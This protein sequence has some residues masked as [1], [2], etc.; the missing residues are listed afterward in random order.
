MGM[1]KASAQQTA[2]NLGVRARTP[3]GVAILVGTVPVAPSGVAFGTVVLVISTAEAIA[4]GITPD[5]DTN[6]KCLLYHHV[7]SFFAR[8]GEGQ[9]LYILLGDSDSTTMAAMVDNT[10][11]SLALRTFLEQQEGECPLIGLFQSEA[12]DYVPARTNGLAT[13]VGTA[14]TNLKALLAAQAAKFNYAVCIVEGKDYS[15]THGQLINHRSAGS[16]LNAPRIAIV[17]DQRPSVRAKDTA[18]A[19]YTE[20]GKLLGVL[21]SVQVN[22]NVGRVKSGSIQDDD[23]GLSSGQEILRMDP[24]ALD[25][26]YDK[27]YIFLRKH[28]KRSGFYYVDDLTLAPA[29]D[30][31]SSL[32]AQRT[33]DKASLIAIDTYTNELLDEVVLLPDGRL[34][35]GQVKNFQEKLR[36]VIADQMGNEI[37]SVTVSIDPDQVVASTSELEAELDVVP[38]GTFRSVKTTVAFKL[39]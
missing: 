21:A 13:I 10:Q 4:A 28:R 33:L 1:P 26:I 9:K 17:L 30:T 3:D 19:G 20:V 8:A 5:F 34:P 25:A 27:G 24:T 29:T 16:S 2:G 32:S 39:S 6:N 15:G 36:E 37:S 14:I 12:T 7:S 23:A 18:F 35:A 22:R 11:A 31:R 38:T